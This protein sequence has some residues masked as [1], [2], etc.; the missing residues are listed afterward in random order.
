MPFGLR[1][2]GF[3]DNT[4]RFAILNGPLV[5]CAEVKP[6]KPFPVVVGN[7]TALRAALKPAAAH[8]NSFTGAPTVF[9]APDGQGREITLEP[10]YKV[11]GNRPYVVYWDSSLH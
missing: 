1:T 7:V 5:L 8:P 6:G 2:E 11:Y 9:R 10:F 4:N 3:R